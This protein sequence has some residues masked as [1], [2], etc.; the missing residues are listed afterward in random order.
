[1]LSFLRRNARWIGAGFLLT[2]CSSFGQT[3]F[4]GQVNAELRAAF[5]LGHGGLALLYG[6]ATAAS[7]ASLPF[8]GQTLDTQRGARVAGWAIPMLAL[9]CLGMA[10]VAHPLMLLG[11][12]YLL[13]LFG[14][15]MMSH[16][17]LTET[18]RWFAASR[19]RATSLVVPGFQAG[20]AT[21]PVLFTLIASLFGWRW[22]WAGAAA[23]LLLVVRPVAVR[24]L[25]VERAPQGE[26]PARVTA[27][28]DWTRA[29]VLRDP[30]FWALLVGVLAPPFIGTTVFYH[31]DYLSDLRGYPPFAFPAA[32]TAM[33]V[34][35]VS[36][37]L[38]CGGLVDRFG[39]TRLLPFFLLPLSVASL[40]V[41]RLD[42]V[43]GVFAFMVL[44][45]VSY[46]FTSTLLGALWPEVYGTRFLGSVRSVVVS[47]MV[48]STALGPVVTGVLIDRGV[49][50]PTQMLWLAAWAL[51]A[52][53]VLALI[54]PRLLARAAR[55]PDALP[56]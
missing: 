4:I 35:T 2:F 17:A 15:G 47:G 21:L 48:L 1:M 13:R 33:A 50:L 32:F 49:A 25:S 20:E 45:G 12:F 34:T 19:G 10:T 14:Q 3:F 9:A 43:W 27:G 23:V 30:L 42:A 31:Q 11:V 37:A 46:G 38:I 24:L 39:A 18:G 53:G 51:G 6:L 8:L 29:E 7:A 5:D 41:A 54:S 56:A 22:A 55:T 28:R 36:C 44:F 26:A 40:A 16:I 52:A